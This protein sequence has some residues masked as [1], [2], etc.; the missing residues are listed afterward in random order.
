MVKDLIL[1]CHNCNFCGETDDATY[2]KTNSKC[3]KCNSTDTYW[4]DPM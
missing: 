2:E 1:S 4:L 3:P